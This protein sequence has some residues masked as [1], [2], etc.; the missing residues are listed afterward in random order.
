MSKLL[1]NVT[2]LGKTAQ[3]KTSRP[4]FKSRTSLPNP[5]EEWVVVEGTHAPLVSQALFDAARRRMAARTCRGEGTFHDRFS[6]LDWCAACGHS[7]SA[8]GTR[9]RGAAADLACGAYKLRG[10]GA[11]TNH[12]IGY[13][14]L[15]A[16]VLGAVREALDLPAEER[17][18]LVRLLGER[19]DREAGERQTAPDR[20]RRERARTEALLRRLY[21]DREAG[22][23]EEGRFRAL[24]ADYQAQARSLE[25]ALAAQEERAGEEEAARAA[26][27]AEALEELERWRGLEEPEEDL[28]FGLLDRIEVGQGR[29]QGREKE[30]R[31]ELRFRFPVPEGEREVLW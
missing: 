14:V 3:G 22:R 16:L 5:P 11:C 20:L 24:L 2:A 23:L 1:R 29:W 4:S 25:E 19:W 18:G 17:E 26:F 31:V 10:K 8:V 13:E 9:R 30:Q 12:F 28:L 21:E 15:T 7:M 27:L 6:G